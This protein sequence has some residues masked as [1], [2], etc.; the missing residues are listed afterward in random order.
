[1][2]MA[3]CEVCGND[4]DKAFSDPYTNPPLHPHAHR[5]SEPLERSP[6]RAAKM[7]TLFG[8]LQPEAAYFCPLD[9]KRG[10]YLVTNPHFSSNS[11]VE[12]PCSA[13]WRRCRRVDLGRARNSPV[14]SSANFARRE[15]TEV[16]ARQEGYSRLYE[17]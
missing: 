5:C 8:K 4:Y 15:V 7:G 11:R 13:D 3:Q 17:P 1:M 14:K 6:A 9:G 10:G 12:V 16:R 2:S